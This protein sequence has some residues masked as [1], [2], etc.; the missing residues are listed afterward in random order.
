MKN[1]II[2][3]LLLIVVVVGYY[4]A[5][6]L[7]LPMENVEGKTERIIR[8][9]LTLPINATGEVKPGLRVEIKSEA[10]GEVIEIAKRPG[11]RVKAGD[12]LIRLQK[13]DE[14]RSVDRATQ[15]L[16]IAEAR[17][18]S[19]KIVLELA[20]GAELATA[21]AQVAQLEPQV[22]YAKYRKDRL[23]KFDPSLKNEE[24]TV[25]RDT[26][27]FRQLALLEGAKAG[28][29][30]AKLNIPRAE[31]EYE[32][33]KASY[34]A[35]KATLGDAQKRLDKT[36]IVSPINGVVANINTQIGA[37]IQGGKTTLTG[38]TVL[39][40]VLDDQ[41]VLVQAEVDESDIGRVLAIAPAWARPGREAALQ[42]PADM[43]KAVEQ[44]EHVTDISVESFREEEFQGVIERIYPEPKSLSNVVTYLVDIVVIGDNRDLLLSGM[45]AE[46]SFTSEHVSN[47]LL[48]PNDAIR[49]GPNG[50]L[51][52]YIPKP[53]SPPSEHE[54]QFVA[55]K[56]G[57]DNGNYNEVREGLQEGQLV[58]TKLPIKREEKDRAKKSSRG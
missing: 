16:Q 15:E 52:V 46:V 47:V 2:V 39:G 56:F 40:V 30:K 18:N 58:Y 7:R 21:Q 10:S 24:E 38:G 14:Q 43:A 3:V 37:V 41:K 11:D 8:G 28:V 33:Y 50:E 31:Y 12:V 35:A 42:M 34:E 54:T 5:T 29:E 25:Q 26:E 6:T 53:G 51:G 36:D 49:D 17:M 22:E 1:A 23:G 44:I 13:D 55:C 20:K 45:R 4:A 19:A 48:C 32:Q 9:D 57:L 27:Y